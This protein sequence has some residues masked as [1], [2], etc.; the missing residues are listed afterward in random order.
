[1]KFNVET[2][3][4]KMQKHYFNEYSLLA[5]DP[6][7]RK[8]WKLMEKIP[9]GKFLDIGCADGSVSFPLIKKGWECYGIELSELSAQR[10]IEKGVH[11]KMTDVSQGISFND[12]FFDVIF[13]GEI[14]E[15]QIDDKLFLSE[16]YRVLKRGGA[17][18][19]TT[20]NLCSLTNR[21][22]ILL[23]FMPRMVWADFHYKIYNQRVLRD[24]VRCAGFEIKKLISSYICVSQFSS[25]HI[26][27]IGKFLG[28]FGERIGNIFPKLGEHII[29]I[30]RKP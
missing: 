26:G 22:L 3:N 20:P 6:K 1:M 30:A 10:A 11:V 5:I 12:S 16:C 23:G 28:F 7:Y 27:W 17:L 9:I 13:A 4:I 24:K 2:T 18:I 29:C 21:I 25:I 14:I 15:H 8:L 19:I